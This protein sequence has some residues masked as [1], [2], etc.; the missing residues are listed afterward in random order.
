MQDIGTPAFRCLFQLKQEVMEEIENIEDKNKFPEIRN[1]KEAAT[2]PSLEETVPEQQIQRKDME[3]HSHTHTPRKKWSHYFWEF[4]MLF[5]A[6][7]CGFLAEYKLEH[8]IENQREETLMRSLTEDLRADEQALLNYYNWRTEINNDFDSVLH[9]LSKPDP[10]NYASLI[11]QKSDASV[12]RFGLPDIHEGT[13]QQLKN[14]GGLRLIRNKK[15]LSEINQHY[16][17]VTR[18]KSIYEVEVLLRVKLAE[19]MGEVLDARLLLGE[20]NQPDSYRLATTEKSKLNNYMN[21]ILAAKQINKRLMSWINS[22]R[23][24]T[25]KLNQL[26]GKEYHL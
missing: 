11:Y 20:P 16:L 24:N 10:D 23:E 12:L 9:L 5:L 26:I 14:A 8:V 21:S 2:I 3:V 6:V 18:M 13:I 4:L 15:V 7:F 1:E 17:N 22:T 19:A 25:I